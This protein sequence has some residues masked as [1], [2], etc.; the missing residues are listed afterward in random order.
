MRMDFNDHTPLL[1]G[2]Y[3]WELHRFFKQTVPGAKVAFDVGGHLGYD[4]LMIAANMD[5][6]VVT[7]EPNPE[8]AEA[9]RGNVELN[10]D[11]AGRVTVSEL[12]VG[13]RDEAGS[14]TL[15]SLAEEHGAPDFIKIDIDGG[16]AD[17]LRGGR[18]L[19][20]TKRPDLIVETHTVELEQEC[21]RLLVDY[22]YRPIVKHNRKIW[23]EYRRGYGTVPHNRW[24]LAPGGES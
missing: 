20:T 22:G 18:E 10:P 12:A 14:A 13:D 15:D 16:E 24:L 19:F 3:E 5:G 9:L 7:F 17:A 4:A 23:K 8:R 6:K 1:L 2:M 21:G 11:F